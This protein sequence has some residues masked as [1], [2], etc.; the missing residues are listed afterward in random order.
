MSS[1][2]PD[3]D[4]TSPPTHATQEQLRALAHP[5][6]L[7][8]VHRVGHRGTARAADLAAD[9]SIP[10]N[11]VSY[12]LRILARGGV[13][14]E[15][16]EAARDRRDR[17]WRLTQTSFYFGNGT[18]SADGTDGDYL[19]ASGAASL[20]AFDRMRSAWAARL[21]RQSTGPDVDDELSSLYASDLRISAA[22]VRELNSLIQTTLAEYNALNRDD[23]GVEIPGDPD[24]EDSAFT[25][26]V[27]W[28][29]TAHRTS[30]EGFASPR[31]DRSGTGP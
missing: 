28:A 29:A 30:A 11:S 13:I 19:A 2:A 22:Q 14:E 21:S 6:R 7:D 18:R 23:Q 1:T 17:V 12:H 5:L 3:D 31:D 8:I 16:P 26:Q 27:L 20:A 10:A 4:S 15:A 9:L 25:Y 24:S